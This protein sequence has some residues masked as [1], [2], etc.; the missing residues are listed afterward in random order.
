MQPNPNTPSDEPTPISS[1]P[2]TNEKTILY[3]SNRPATAY[4]IYDGDLVELDQ[5][6]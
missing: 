5:A 4:L 6:L 3:D 2:L 1:K